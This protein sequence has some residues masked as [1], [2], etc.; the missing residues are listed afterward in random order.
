ME[1]NIR[2]MIGDADHERY[3]LASQ[4]YRPLFVIGV[5]PSIANEEKP[6]RTI[7]RIMNFARQN[8]YDGFVMLNLYPQRSTN[9]SQVHQE[10]DSRLHKRN[11]KEIHSILTEYTNIHILVAFGNLIT[12]RKYLTSCFRDI[13]EMV[14]ECGIDVTWL[15]IGAL[16]KAGHPR[17]PLYARYDAGVHLFD[18][19]HYLEKQR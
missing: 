5:N 9:F 10:M 6:D 1:Y 14:S 16:T 11:L 4:G 17:H 2:R 3:V 13:V 19:S 15:Q 7:G 12:Q 18:L 8:G